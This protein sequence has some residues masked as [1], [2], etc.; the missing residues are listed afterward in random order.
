MTGLDT[1]RLGKNSALDLRL[2]GF[3]FLAHTPAAGE[4]ASFGELI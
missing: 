4:S 1:L 2:Q 3:F